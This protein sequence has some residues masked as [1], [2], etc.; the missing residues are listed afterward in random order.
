[1]SVV[2]KQKREVKV[3]VRMHDGSRQLGN[4]FLGPDERLQDILNDDRIFLPVHVD[5]QQ[6]S[7]SLVML[8]KR[9][10][11]Q[12]EE[13]RPEAVK[14]RHEEVYSHTGQRKRTLEA[15]PTKEEVKA[16][17]PLNLELD[18]FNPVPPKKK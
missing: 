10:I 15:V 1:M 14:R 16:P 11:Q 7:A 18:D 17:R 12:I 9:Y 6:S 13:V 3:Y 5:D 8:S 4:V 2:L